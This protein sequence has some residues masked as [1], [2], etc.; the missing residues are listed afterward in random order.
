LIDLT[1]PIG[2]LGMDFFSMLVFFVLIVATLQPMLQARYQAMQ[3]ARQISAI[4]QER[5]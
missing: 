2:G 4:E 5:G 3:R 1:L